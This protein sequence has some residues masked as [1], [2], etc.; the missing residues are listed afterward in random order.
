MSRRPQ[1]HVVCDQRSRIRRHHSRDEGHDQYGLW[2]LVKWIILP[3][4]S[5]WW[6]RD[7]ILTE[8][9]AAVCVLHILGISI[10]MRCTHWR[11]T[12]CAA[13]CSQAKSFKCSREWCP[14]GK[15]MQLHHFIFQLCS[16]IKS[17]PDTV[18]APNLKLLSS[19]W[20]V[21]QIIHGFAA[22]QRGHT[23]MSHMQLF[24]VGFIAAMT[25]CWLTVILELR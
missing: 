3:P 9:I 10:D 2:S 7:D 15:A 6:A 23:P 18:C 24:F 5:W 4:S 21:K 16:L 1:R 20:V 14:L 25:C 11:S 17:F 12:Q 8:N 22:R 19:F 13:S